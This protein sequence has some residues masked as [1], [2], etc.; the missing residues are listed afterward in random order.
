MNALDRAWLG[1]AILS[2]LTTA[3]ALSPIQA[4]Y[5]GALILAFA[6]LKA[7]LIFLW[8][9]ELVDVPGWR[10][11]LLFGLALFMVVLFGLYVLV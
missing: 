9:L 1:L 8:Y 2:A 4:P 11:G 10:Q 5:S 3:T 7:R 6:W